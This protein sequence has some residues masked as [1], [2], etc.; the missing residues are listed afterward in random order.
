[1]TEY[2]T[3]SEQ[4]I[5]YVYQEMSEAES[6]HFEQHLRDNEDLMQEYLDHLHTLDRLSEVKLEPSETIVKAIKKK[7]KSS[8]LERV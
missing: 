2:F 1:M 3:L 6:I 4:L 8:G 7:A 5:R